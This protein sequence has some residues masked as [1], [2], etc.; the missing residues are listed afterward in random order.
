MAYPPHPRAGEV[1]ALYRTGQHSVREIAAALGMSPNTAARHVRAAGIARGRGWRP[2]RPVG[3]RVLLRLS[4][5]RAEL[6]AEH[7]RSQGREVVEID[8]RFI[9]KGADACSQ[10]R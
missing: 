4:P 2:G 7:F 9:L 6:L 8:G 1:A 5:R 10:S 3:R